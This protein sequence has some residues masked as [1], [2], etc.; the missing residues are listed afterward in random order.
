MSLINDLILELEERPEQAGRTDFARGLS[1]RERA[2]ERRPSNRAKWLATAGSAAFIAIALLWVLAVPKAS[3]PPAVAARPASAVATTFL[4]PETGVR[5][6]RRSESREGPDPSGDFVTNPATT[7]ARIERPVI[8]RG[9]D[10]ER[11]EGRVSLR[12][13]TNG[14][15]RHVTHRTEDP[16]RL[17]L[18]LEGARL[19]SWR[20]ALD[21]V[22]TPIR[23]V[24]TAPRD[25]SLH[26]TLELDPGTRIRTQSIETES[27]STLLVDLVV[28]TTGSDLA[29]RAR[30]SDGPAYAPDAA[31]QGPARPSDASSADA[32]MEIELSLAER[33]RRSRAE[34]RDRA[35][36]ATL[37][38]R[39]AR[40]VGDLD[41]AGA[42]FREALAHDARHPTALVEW[43][44][45]LRDSGRLEEAIA[46]A[47]RAHAS[48]SDEPEIVMLLA[49]LLDDGGHRDEALQIL[50]ASGSSVTQAPELHALAAAI[51]QRDERHE[52]AV[53]RYEA[54]VRRY[55][56]ESKW[57]L[58]LGISLDALARG[59]EAADVYR[60]AMQ[61]GTLPR[62]S[63]QWAAARIERLDAEE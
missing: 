45:L 51:L 50:E 35:D 29:D 39:R 41:A 22:D 53:V 12:I 18:R 49:R 5:A 61:L 15:T 38:A 17:E 42:Y 55:P 57:W 33:A 21:L 31:A 52:E 63:R 27:G 47:A 60:I 54:I 7:E 19:G 43:A 9:I 13:S 23:A 8:L 46:L 62:A 25:G 11:H 34:A 28:S 58:G 26:L 37:A 6:P 30:V 59:T 2:R 32:T 1:P 48:R 14:R 44:A 40:E 10:L 16:N 3:S 20:P 56:G 4:A 24:S 36:Q